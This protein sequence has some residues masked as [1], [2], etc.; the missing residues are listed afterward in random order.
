MDIGF[1]FS[2][3]GPRS[4]RVRAYYVGGP[5]DLCG[6]GATEEEAKASLL[7]NAADYVYV[8]GSQEGLATNQTAIQERKI[9]QNAP[10]NTTDFAINNNIP[11]PVKKVAATRKGRKA[12]Y[13]FDALEVGQSFFVPN[14]CLSK[15]ARKEGQIVFS[16]VPARKRFPDRKFV[17]RAV[18]EQ[19]VL[20]VRVWRTATEAEAQ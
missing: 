9:V 14:A 11:V 13:P 16:A 4:E 1:G 20:G 2:V 19:G 3:V 7:A 5:A 12:R 8:D 18:E 6:Y 15:K 17:C 10:Q